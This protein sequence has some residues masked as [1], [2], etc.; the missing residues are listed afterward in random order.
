MNRRWFL[1]STSLIGITG[2]A[3]CPGKA[4]DVQRTTRTTGDTEEPTRTPVKTTAETSQSAIL[5]LRTFNYPDAITRGQ[6]LSIEM[7]I[8]NGGERS[9]DTEVILKLGDYKLTKTIVIQPNET[10]TIEFSINKQLS[11]G[12]YTITAIVTAAEIS[13]RKELKVKPNHLKLPWTQL[14][15]P[16]GGPVTDIAISKAN[17]NHIYAS[18]FTAGLYSSNDGGKSWRQ[19]SGD[20][21]HGK[22]VSASP[23]DPLTAREASRNLRT[24]NGGRYWYGRDYPQTKVR[25]PDAQTFE[26][27]YDP[28]DDQILYAGAKEGIYR[29]HD[30]GLNWQRVELDLDLK[31]SEEVT[32]IVAHPKNE[33]VV[34]ATFDETAE[35]VRSTD[36]GKT[37]NLWVAAD[38]LPSFV[39]TRDLALSH[40]DDQTVYISL[41]E[42]GI[43]RITNGSA[44]EITESLPS[45]SY[46][47]DDLALS[48]D[49]ERL[50]FI[51]RRLL[52]N[53][54]FGEWELR[55]YTITDGDIR[56]IDVPDKPG[57]VT[58]HPL[59]SSTIF[60]GGWSWVHKSTDRGN[61]WNTLSDGFINHYLSTVAV[62]DSHPGTVFPGT[63]CSGGLFAS[64]DHGETFEW[65]RSGLRPY[66]EGDWGMHY[67]HDVTAGG[68]HAYAT[69]AAGLLI[70]D[71]NGKTWHTLT[72]EFSGRGVKY[73]PSTPLGGVAID[74][75]D[76]RTVYVGTVMGRGPGGAGN[77]IFD[78]TYIYKSKNGGDTWNEITH[79]FPTDA[80]SIVQE[81]L[82]SHHDSDV[83]FLGT[84]G[85][86][87]YPHGVASA[88]GIGLYKSATGGAQWKKLSTPFSNVF[89]LSEDAKNPKQIYASTENGAYRSQD[90]GNTWE[91]ILPYK[92][93]AVLAHPEEE[94]TVFAGAQKYPGYWDLLVSDDGGGLWVEGNLTIESRS[95]EN[96]I[97]HVPEN[98]EYDGFAL[99]GQGQIIDLSIEDSHSHL[100][101]A[102]RGAG[103][104]RCDIS[105]VTT[106]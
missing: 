15:G 67:V 44:H 79:G 94:G 99:D 54:E 96:P 101:A 59:E 87:G 69:T 16:Q 46:F 48:A 9:T 105:R 20:R 3:G 26:F 47:Y 83:I 32:D 62:N 75:Q 49:D 93:K 72:N 30:K 4:D 12:S 23:H 5:A 2:L 6:T 41:G 97:E 70:S 33:G 25:S 29:T 40:S 22:S 28:F 66:H 10:K 104:W 85:N 57:S 68:K 55:E 89:S 43:F 17:P 73:E 95:H 39:D 76:P 61:T 102:T 91:Q 100:I 51:T 84:K 52:D 42:G 31:S 65:K 106:K 82:V 1:K 86:E 88:E 98:R 71:D 58:A 35:I 60:L 21:H 50:Y 80:I 63:I 53:G 45:N 77:A 14:P 74:P 27:A 56:T 18:T 92:T 8:E 36:Y 103:L 81:I 34:Y 37:W 19:A 90:G 13:I 64:W 78:G 7:T 24:T 11:P 38:E